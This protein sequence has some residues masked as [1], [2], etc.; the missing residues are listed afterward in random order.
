VFNNKYKGEYFDLREIS[1]LETKNFIPF[2]AVAATNQV[3]WMARTSTTKGQKNR[4][5]LNVYG[6]ETPLKTARRC[7]NGKATS[8]C[9]NRRNLCRR[10]SHFQAT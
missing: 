5:T 4:I 1:G 10:V 2:H 7:E 9:F 6:K 3:M 8:E